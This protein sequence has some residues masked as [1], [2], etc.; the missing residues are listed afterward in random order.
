MPR[1]LDA[2]QSLQL[3]PETAQP[4]VDLSH[5]QEDSI[6]RA[7]DLQRGDEKL[8]F[9]DT[10]RVQFVNDPEYAMNAHGAGGGHL[11]QQVVARTGLG[12]CPSTRLC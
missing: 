9:A 6:I 5:G 7:P 4:L 3:C 1:R 8:D 2:R 12:C 11:A 10:G